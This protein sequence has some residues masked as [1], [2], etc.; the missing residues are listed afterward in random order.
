MVWL[1]GCMGLGLVLLAACCDGRELG[2]I[3]VGNGWFLLLVDVRVG[4][5][6]V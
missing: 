3:G 5:V 2:L 6:V 4:V 1:C